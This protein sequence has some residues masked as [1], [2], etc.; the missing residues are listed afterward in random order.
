MWE[1]KKLSASLLAVA[2]ILA[3]PGCGL[4]GDQPDS[5]SDKESSSKEEKDAEAIPVEVSRLTRGDIRATIE[6]SAHLEAEERVNVFSRTSNLVAELRVEEG[7]QVAKGELLLRLENEEQTIEHEKAKLEYEK[8]LE[9]YRREES[10]HKQGLISDETFSQIRFELKQRKLSLKEARRRLSY[11]EIRSPIPGTVTD[12][13]VNVG[14]YVRPQEQLFTIINFESIVAKVY[15][16]EEHLPELKP[17][18]QA[19]LIAIGLDNRH[20]E[21]SVIRVAPTVDPKT[22]TV[23]VTVAPAKVGPLRPGLFVRASVATRTYDDAVLIPKRALIYDEDRLYVYC[24]TSEQT[25][26]RREVVPSVMNEVYVRPE[27]G[28]DVGDAIVTAGQ[29]GLQEGARVRVVG[30][31]SAPAPATST[32][33]FSP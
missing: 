27:S 14:D 6:G 21:A 23:K 13:R 8:L 33:Q 4:W 18:Q 9:D 25:A 12:R 29:T 15:L 31:P 20:F 3:C 11:T 1:V 22:G 7:G 2:L 26:E 24:V 10:L 17:G 5:S 30:S 28:F 32:A 16:P 19:E